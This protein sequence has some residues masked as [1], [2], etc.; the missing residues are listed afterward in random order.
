MLRTALLFVRSAVRLVYAELPGP[1][2]VCSPKQAHCE[3][4]DRVPWVA[5]AT[6][7]TIESGVTSAPAPT[8][9]TGSAPTASTKP[10]PS[11]CAGAGAYITSASAEP[12]GDRSARR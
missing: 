8:P 4:G 9:T 5:T 7:S 1:V 10:A 11:A 6:L 3:L 2:A 12:N